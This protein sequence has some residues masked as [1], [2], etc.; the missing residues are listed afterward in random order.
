[1]RDEIINLIRRIAAQNGGK[2]PGKMTFANETGITETKWSGIYWARWGDALAEAGFKPNA[3]QGRLDSG[4][5]LNKIVEFAKLL[6]RL[7]TRAEMKL[8]RRTDES[9]PSPN[10]IDNHFCGGPEL[11]AALTRR[12][13]ENGDAA[14]LL[15]LPEAPVEPEPDSESSQLGVVYLLKSGEHYKIGRSDNIDRRVKEITVALPETLTL[16]HAI[17][18]DDA[19]GI[20][21]YWHKRF[22]DRRANGEWFRLSKHDV[23]AFTRR[24]FQ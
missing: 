19:P 2:A 8:R 6:G 9:F 16:I 4:M 1:M 12:S 5:I 22:A 14:L 21:A 15:L 3:L 10:T 17:K 13:I 7:P 18:T 24:K 20:E 23:R 11:F